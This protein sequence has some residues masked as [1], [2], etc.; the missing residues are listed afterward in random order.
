M[1]KTPEQVAREGRALSLHA[2]RAWQAAR[3]LYCGGG[4]AYPAAVRVA[5]NADAARNAWLDDRGRES[6]PEPA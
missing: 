3:D 1:G 4:A 6:A 2:K 5:L